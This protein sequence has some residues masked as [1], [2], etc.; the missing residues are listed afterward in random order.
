MFLVPAKVPASIS[1]THGFFSVGHMHLE[2]PR[3]GLT[4]TVLGGPGGKGSRNI[5]IEHN[6]GRDQ[7]QAAG[8]FRFSSES[9]FVI[10]GLSS[11][12]KKN[13]TNILG[14]RKKI[15]QPLN[16]IQLSKFPRQ[17]I[18]SLKGNEEYND[19]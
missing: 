8:E 17:L 12:G 9:N 13:L 3:V 15:N 4:A 5:F 7:R 1:L 10:T 11:L 2:P 6:E 16:K 14:K 18:H 19:F